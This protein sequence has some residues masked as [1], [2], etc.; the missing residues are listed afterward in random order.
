LNP[1]EH[2]FQALPRVRPFHPRHIFRGAFSDES[3]ARRTAFWTQ[4]NDTIGS[5]HDIKVVL[6]K[7]FKEKALFQ[8][9]RFANLMF[10]YSLHSRCF[11]L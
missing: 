2:H 10:I 5:L 11:T 9:E 6:D 3:A 1:L 4:V 8:Q 7:P